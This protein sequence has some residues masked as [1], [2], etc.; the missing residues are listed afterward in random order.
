VPLSPCW[1][2]NYRSSSYC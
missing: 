2:S 1:S